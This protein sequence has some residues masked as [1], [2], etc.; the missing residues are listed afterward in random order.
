MNKNKERRIK[1]LLDKA[2]K[3]IIKYEEEDCRCEHMTKIAPSWFVCD[4]CGKLFNFLISMQFSYE[5]ALEHFG[6]LLSGLD[7]AKDIIRAAEAKREALEK[8][9]EKEALDNYIKEN[10]I[11]KKKN[12]AEA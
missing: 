8:Q 5:Q 6:K 3:R 2:D 9:H 4:D 1:K 7:A 12:E 10:K 11:S